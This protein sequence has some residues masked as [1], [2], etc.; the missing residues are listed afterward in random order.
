MIQTELR[1]DKGVLIAR[2]NGPLAKENFATLSR[3]IDAYIESH[4]GLNGLVLC[5]ERFPGWKN[6]QGLWSH[7][8]FVRSH[9]QKVNKVALV[10]NTRILKLVISIAKHFVHPE[11]RFFKYDQ[12]PSAIQWIGA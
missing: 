11:V 12:E 8:Q 7:F 3:E 10:T 2:P 9:H 6:L 4:G 5:Y 1:S